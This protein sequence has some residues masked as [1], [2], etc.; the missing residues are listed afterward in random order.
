M[1]NGGFAEALNSTA[2]LP[3]DCPEAFGLFV[4][5]IYQDKIELPKDMDEVSPIP[6]FIK[7]FGFAEKYG[8]VELADKM[9]DTLIKVMVTKDWH[10]K[11]DDMELAYDPE[12]IPA[13]SKLRL[14][15]SRSFVYLTLVHNEDLTITHWNR[16]FMTDA[17][18][19]TPELLIDAFGLM[20]G[21]AGVKPMDARYASACDYHRHGEGLPCPYTSQLIT[22]STPGSPK[23]VTPKSGSK[24][25]RG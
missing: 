18:M 23:N 1:F 7:L 22:V 8:I 16:N 14:L 9:I 19:R 10:P 24:R 13:H 4:A 25:K 3:E 21:Q 17:A 15:M 2:T 11:P 6:I 5:W 20:R 12:Y